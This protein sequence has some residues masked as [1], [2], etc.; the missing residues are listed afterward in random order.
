MHTLKKGLDS[1]IKKIK[2]KEI[3]IKAADKRSIVVTM[4]PHYHWNICQSHISDTSY[5]RMLNNTDPSNIVQQRVTKFGD[6]TN[7]C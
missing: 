1:V 7:Q 3:A 6:N 4:Y 2:N 5:Y